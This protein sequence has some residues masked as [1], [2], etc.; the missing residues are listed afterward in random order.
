MKRFINWYNKSLRNKVIL[1]S[2]IFI[3]ALM[4]S[5]LHRPLGLAIFCID[6]YYGNSYNELQTLDKLNKNMM[7]KD[8]FLQLS[9][10]YN[11]AYKVKKH[12]KE[13]LEYINHFTTDL[14]LVNLLGLEDWY[15]QP[16]LI[17]AKMYVLEEGF[18]TAYKEH[19]KIPITKEDIKSTLDFLNSFD[20]IVF[21]F[22]KISLENTQYKRYMLQANLIR[23][24]L[25]Q[26]KISF[27]V[28]LENRLCSVVD[29]QAK[30]IIS[31]ILDN[32]IQIYSQDWGELEDNDMVEFNKNEALN[33][34][35]KLKDKL[36]GC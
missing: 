13:F 25:I 9:D 21:F 22:N 18:Y 35:A 4:Y 20:E 30:I 10:G 14:F 15:Y 28:F 6:S 24:L 17:K 34:I 26:P 16:L 27:L 29:N 23:F 32:V 2:I 7:Y 8:I 33:K 19:K 12:K 1:F 11:L 3:F 5:F 31:E 36:N